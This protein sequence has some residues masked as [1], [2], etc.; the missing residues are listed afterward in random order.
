M[1]TPADGADDAIGGCA[2]TVLT[3]ISFHLV[4]SLACAA[5]G[6]ANA[7]ALPSTANGPNRAAFMCVPSLSD[8]GRAFPGCASRY[9]LPPMGRGS[10]CL[11]LGPQHGA[12]GAGEETGLEEQRVNRRLTDGL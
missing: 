5:I 9:H 12:A 11:R 6:S 7:T 10:Q 2:S 4:T 1:N 3:A 8:P